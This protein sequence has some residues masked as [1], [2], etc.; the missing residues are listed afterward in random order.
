[1]VVP[2]TRTLGSRVVVVAWCIC[3]F[4]MWNHSWYVTGRPSLQRGT[5][6]KHMLTWITW[7]LHVEISTLQKTKYGIISV[8]LQTH[9]LRIRCNSLLKGKNLKASGSNTKLVRPVSKKRANKKAR[10]YP[11][12]P[13]FSIASSSSSSSSSFYSYYGSR[14]ERACCQYHSCACWWYDPWCKLGSSRYS[15]QIAA[16]TKRCCY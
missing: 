5:N 16:T 10:P 1:M 13:F 12:P 11:I 6:Q 9:G 3:I 14:R 8:R 4:F 7:E 15:F 2:H